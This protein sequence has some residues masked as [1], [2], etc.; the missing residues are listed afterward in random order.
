MPEFFH[1]QSA[2]GFVDNMYTLSAFV[3]GYASKPD[4]GYLVNAYSTAL[5][6]LQ[7]R[8]WDEWVPS[9]A[10][11]SDLPSRLEY[12]KYYEYFPDSIW[13]EPVLPDLTRWGAS[14]T[15]LQDLLRSRGTSMSQLRRMVQEHKRK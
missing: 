14:L 10:N 1:R 13:V 9:D 6:A 3:H 15:Q 4:M 11:I 12:D 5:F 2:F 8:C 7:L